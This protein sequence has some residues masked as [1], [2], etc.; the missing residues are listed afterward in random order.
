MDKLSSLKDDSELTPCCCVLGMNAKQLTLKTLLTSIIGSIFVLMVLGLSFI[1]YTSFQGFNQQEAVKFRKQQGLSVSIQVDQYAASVRQQ[2]EMISDAINYQYGQVQNESAVV[3]LLAKL[4][5]TASGTATYIVFS[6]G[7]SLESTGEKFTDIGLEKQWYQG[8]KSG[9]AFVLT[10]PNID[11][12][13]GK[14]LSSLVVPLIADGDFI[15]VVGVD[16]SS[17]VWA[18]LVSQNVPDGQL[19]LTD[20]SNRVLY[21]PKPEYLGKDFFQVQPKYRHFPQSHLQYSDAAGTELIATQN[22]SAEFGLNVYT[23]EKMDV[24]MAPSKSM[25]NLSLVSAL[26]FIAVS[27][28][29]IYTIIVKLIY[30]PIGG[31]PTQIQ[32]IIERISAGDLTVDAASTGKD[33][34]VYAATVVMVE[35]LKQM[36]GN[37]NAQSA[38]VEFTAREL[39]SLVE[40][41]KQSSD[42]QINQMEMTATAMNE[43]TA[44]VEEIS[45][46]AQHASSSATEAFEQAQSGSEIANESS[47]KMNALGQEINDV[48][49]RIDD[50]RQQTVNVGDVLSVIREIADQTNLLA[51]NAAIEAARAGEQGRGFAVVADEVRSLASRTQDSVAEVNATIEKLQSVAASAVSSMNQSQDNTSEAIEMAMKAR[52]SLTAIL[53]SVGQIQD[54]NTHIATAAEEQNAVAQEINQSVVEVNGLAQTTNENA[55]TTERST[56]QLSSVVDELAAITSKFNV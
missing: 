18:N 2:L 35:K 29:I 1:S 39:A 24:I 32:S 9:K 31:E 30:V 3:K 19:Y 43:M 14:L 13:T 26:L 45:R 41:T 17:D 16:I 27:L 20:A 23:F 46:N 55:I 34:G 49:E 11:Q 38:Q 51:L 6:D 37:I 47:Q 42:K 8:P 56:Q 22:R 7:T 25:L 33:T 5:R 10:E 44:T 48:S 36:V 21:S 50:L 52:D 54:M 28:M 40:E 12:V 4:H 53:T 15:G